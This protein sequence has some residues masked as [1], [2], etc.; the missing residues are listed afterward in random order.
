MIDASAAAAAARD[1]LASIWDAELKVVYGQGA[2]VNIYGLAVP[3]NE[4]WVVYVPQPLTG[5]RSSE[6][7]IIEKRSGAVVYHGL[8]FDEG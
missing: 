4:C 7:I 8:A 1:H 6:V 3:L 2:H 5:F